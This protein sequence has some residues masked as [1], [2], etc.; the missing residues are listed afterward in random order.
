MSIRSEYLEPE[1]GRELN[2]PTPVSP[3]LNYKRAPSLAE[4]IREM[5]RSE[6]LAQALRSQ[7]VETFEEADDFDVG[8]DFDPS[9]PY[10]ANFDLPQYN[11]AQTVQDALKASQAPEA[12][13]EPQQQKPEAPKA[14]PAGDQQSPQSQAPKA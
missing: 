10:E 4:Q 13:K 7:G 1:S 9:S 5:V 8:D 12:P 6:A 2:D 11:E 3:P 14:P